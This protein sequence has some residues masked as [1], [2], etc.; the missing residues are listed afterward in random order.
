MV[1]AGTERLVLRGVDRKFWPAG[2]C[3]YCGADDALHDLA[4]HEQVCEGPSLVATPTSLPLAPLMPTLP[5]ALGLRRQLVPT[6]PVR[7]GE[8]S[9]DAAPASVAPSQPPHRRPPVIERRP[10]RYRSL[11]PSG[12]S[13]RWVTAGV[14]TAV[15]AVV[16]FA[17]L[18][19][20]GSVGSTSAARPEEADAAAV[21]QAAAPAPTPGQP[22]PEGQASSGAL[23]LVKQIAL[24]RE[25]FDAERAQVAAALPG[26]LGQAGPAS[27]ER[28]EFDAAGPEVVALGTSPESSEAALRDTA[29]AITMSM[30]PLWDPATMRRVPNAVPALRLAVNRL[31]VR[32][33]PGF[34]LQLAY[35]QRSQQEWA[36]ECLEV[37]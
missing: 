13:S 27:L 24:D 30:L 23:S 36:R 8:M 10:P 2:Q 32:C 21:T 16:G 17:T 3:K 14:G 12:P 29:W 1:T 37:R 31:Q 11:R 9:D 25:H 22:G 6:R 19:R 18:G 26:A 34:M 5:P 15:L 33:S 20:S 7:R 35:G 4:V 28:L